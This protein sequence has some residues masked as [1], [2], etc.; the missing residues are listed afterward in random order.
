MVQALNGLTTAATLFITASGLTLVFGVTRIVNFA[1]GSFYMLGAYLAATLIPHLVQAL[2]PSIG[3]WSGIVLSSLTVGLIGV[4]FELLVLRRVY[5]TSELYQ[6]LATFAAV[7]VMSDLVIIIFGRDDIFGMKAPGLENSVEIL[8][9]R[10]PSYDLFVIA[11]GVAVLGALML[12]LRKTRFG[13]LVRA[14]TQ[15]RAM[16]G[17]LGV[18][19]ALLFTGI[20]FL[21]SFLAGLGGA[22]QTPRLPANSQM[23][24]SII[25]ECFVVTV[26][27]GMGSIPGAFL[28]ALLIGQLQAFGILILPKINLVLVFLLMAVVLVVRPWGFLGRPETSTQAQLPEEEWSFAWT[29]RHYAILAVLLAALAMLPA[30]VDGYALKV[31]TEMLIMSLYAVSLHFLVVTG[32]LISFGHAAY[33]GLGAYGAALL[34]KHLQLPMEI[35]L[36]GAPI[37]AALGAALF[38]Y[39]I[40]RLKGTYLAM[41]SLAAAQIVYAVAFQSD[42]TGGDNGLIGIR[43]SAWAASRGAYY[44]L[45]LAVVLVSLAVLRHLVNSP[46]GF[47]LRAT[48]DSETRAA[49]VG[50]N[51]LSHRWIAFTV[52]GAAAGVAGGLHAFM[53]GSVDP[54]LLSVSTSVD[55]LIMLLL[56]GLQSSAG[57]IIGA[58]LLHEMKNEFIALTDYWRLFLGVAIILLIMT[59]P[60]GTIGALQQARDK[61]LQLTT[62]AVTKSIQG[63]ANDLA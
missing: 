31:V 33:F 20:L 55:G 21:G 23:D 32:G 50:I 29:H 60:R 14:A 8:G 40:V 48:R 46:F 42:F 25:T 51:V 4:L 44:Y 22:L 28:A 58:V 41:L 6:L 2:S 7:L 3:F 13:V 36:A 30:L 35:S 45:A 38:G 57:A 11:L 18:N 15:D 34:V 27:G 1:H 61:L 47:T 43:P 37:V 39:F 53:N 9:R 16:V 26:V 24:I 63:G 10:F 52:A 59:M 54:T 62:K 17:V 19:Q 12:L 49:A 5:R 56:G